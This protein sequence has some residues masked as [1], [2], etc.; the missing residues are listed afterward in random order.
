MALDS[1]LLARLRQ[2]ISEPDDTNGWTDVRIETLA[3]EALQPDGTY[4]TRLFAAVLWEAK[5]AD[6]SILVNTQESG[7]SRAMGQVFDH[8]TKMAERY[9]AAA[10]A[11]GAAPTTRPRSTKITRAIP[12]G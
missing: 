10:S 5:A 7:S 2:L 9:R 4:D 6:A 11:P 1:A 3:P 8:A 12:G